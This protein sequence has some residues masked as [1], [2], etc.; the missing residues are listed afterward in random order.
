MTM[1]I[2]KAR[3]PEPTGAGAEGAGGGGGHEATAPG[4]NWGS[5][6]HTSPRLEKSFLGAKA[7]A[8]RILLSWAR[9]WPSKHMA[10]C[11]VWYKTQA[12]FVNC[13]TLM[14]GAPWI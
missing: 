5:V 3:A 6:V 11:V 2:G 13:F 8:S 9:G 1:P 4:G 14:M 7:R 10:L 12:S